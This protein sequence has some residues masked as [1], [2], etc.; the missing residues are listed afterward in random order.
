MDYSQLA[1]STVDFLKPVLVAEGGK[2]AA[3][4]VGAAG[5]ELL[6][7]LKGR[8]T[9]PSQHAVLEEAVQSP[10]D[11]GALEALQLQIRLAL[12]RQE[13]FAKDLLERLPKE[14]RPQTAET[15][16][17]IGDNNKGVQNT[18]SGNTISI[19]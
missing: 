15:M 5:K 12:E 4:G 3:A 16:I 11:S 14:F 7:W 1:Q 19:Q 13:E 9:K 8:F 10:E 18:G 17:V 2:I 6:S